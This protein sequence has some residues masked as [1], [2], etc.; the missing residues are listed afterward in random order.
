MS[1]PPARLDP[2]AVPGTAAPDQPGRV[3]ASALP[4][5]RLL[6][7]ARPWTVQALGWLLAA[8]ACYPT[9][10]DK[11]GQPRFKLDAWIYQHAVAQWQA[12][13]L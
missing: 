4:G 5:S 7:W 3:T 11:A 10:W 9:L 13:R 6:S 2:C 12:R 8:L 1:T